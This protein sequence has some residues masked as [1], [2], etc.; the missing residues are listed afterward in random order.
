MKNFLLNSELNNKKLKTN[1]MSKRKKRLFI[2]TIEIHQD[3]WNYKK[4]D[5]VRSAVISNN[6]TNA[7]ETFMN[8]HWGS[9]YPLYEITKIE[10]TYDTGFFMPNILSKNLM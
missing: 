1:K 9:E 3:C 7:F 5:I 6:E 8:K 2:V 10:D 4:G